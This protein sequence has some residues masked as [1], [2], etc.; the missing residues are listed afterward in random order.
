MQVFQDFLMW[1]HF[2]EMGIEI[3]KVNVSNSFHFDQFRYRIQVSMFN[4]GNAEIVP[5]KSVQRSRYYR[6][7]DRQ[8]T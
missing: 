2:D 4:V 3:C 1:R 8:E 6:Q 5:H 7:L